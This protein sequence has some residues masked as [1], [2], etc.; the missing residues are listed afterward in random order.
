MKSILKIIKEVIMWLV[1]LSA[2]AA[3][4]L[5]TQ[6]PVKSSIIWVLIGIVIFVGGFLLAKYGKRQKGTT[7]THLIFKK[8]I[9]A[10]LTIFGLILPILILSTFPTST[11][12]LIV[13][14]DVVLVAFGIL[15][16]KLINKSIS[17]AILGYILLF[18]LAF[19]PALAMSTYDMSYNA[20]GT[21]YYL[22]I[23]LA[24][25]SWFGIS[26]IYTK[27]LQ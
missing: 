26:M 7:H 23:A 12:L 9:G 14:F 8:I 4:G 24:C 20:L 11:K 13:A 15:A 27:E 5:S 16:V 3:I 1:I 17:T 21:T 18:I 25:F 2:F 19:L 10:L 6:T 22:T